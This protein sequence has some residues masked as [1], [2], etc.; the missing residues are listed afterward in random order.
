MK[1]VEKEIEIDATPEAVWNAIAQAEE[2]KRWFTLDARVKPGAG[3][4]IWMSFGEGME[5]E[6]PIEVWDEGRHLRTTEGEAPKKMAIDYF[7]ETRGGKTVLRLV[8]SGFAD[9]TWDDEL[10]TLNSGWAAFLANLKHYLENHSGEPR[11]VAFF[12]HDPV[13]IPRAEAF[14]RTLRALGFNE[15]PAAGDRYSVTTETGDHFEG[16]IKVAA[17]PI[18]LTMSVENRNNGWLMMEMEPGRDQT[19]PAIWLSL[20]GNARSE[21]PAMQT[22]IRELL[23]REFG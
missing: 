4:A 11:E 7:I 2:I 14:A 19:R 12:R 18:N 23:V 20:Y 8:H 5:W 13:A 9:D 1:K 16:V 17:P 3:G 15:P 6:S 21:A 22:R 10:D